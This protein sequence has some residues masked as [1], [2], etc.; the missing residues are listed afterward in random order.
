MATFL[1]N[2]TATFGLAEL[3]IGGMLVTAL[4]M[5]TRIM[6]T[7]ETTGINMME[8]LSLRGSISIYTGWLCAA[9]ILGMSIFLKRLEISFLND[10]EAEWTVAIL[11]V[12]L[13]IYAANTYVRS[14]FLYGSVLIWAGLA[15]RDN[16][17]FGT[18]DPMVVSNLNFIIP[19][20][21]ALDLYVLV[22]TLL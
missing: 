19:I 16:D 9:T 7:I 2:K 11:W 15:I 20:I 13:T 10:H 6:E 3:M 14:D 4:I 1:Q 8:M 18:V 5:Q 12:A 17:D 22:Q 21:A